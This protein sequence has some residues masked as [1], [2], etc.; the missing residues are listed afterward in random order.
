MIVDT[1]C[2]SA[3]KPDSQTRGP[4]RGSLGGHYLI[5]IGTIMIIIAFIYLLIH[6][7]TKM[8]TATQLSK[9]LHNAALLSLVVVVA[10]PVLIHVTAPKYSMHL[11]S[12]SDGELLT[13]AATIMGLAVFGS[14]L[15]TLGG[16]KY[17]IKG[18]AYT[19]IPLITVQAVFMLGLVGLF[20]FPVA[21]WIIMT[22]ILLMLTV[23]AMVANKV[24][25]DEAGGKTT[26]SGSSRKG[27]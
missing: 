13:A 4:D 22:A 20:S 26:A 25:S 3:F 14:A 27:S 11:D 24:L 7:P 16:N 18:I 10:I 8:I 17:M 6:R 12:V 15:S 2:M 21:A 5:L 1:G 23:L 9:G 19:I